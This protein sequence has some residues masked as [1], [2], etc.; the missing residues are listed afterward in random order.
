MAT[1]NKKTS[2]LIKALLETA[3]EMK[4]TGILGETAYEKITMR[5]LG[6]K[7]KFLIEP[8]TGEEIRMMREQAHMSQA[9]FAHY[10]N[11][12]VGYVSQLERGAKH[13]TGA[14]L[15]LLNVIHR[16]GIEAIL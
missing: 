11:L 1:K 6:G 13:P 2:G 12:T 14:V 4:N 8:L 3:S 9:V 15:V 7:N 16:K 10:L 5:H